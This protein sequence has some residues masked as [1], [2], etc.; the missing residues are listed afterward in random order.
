MPAQTRILEE[1]ARAGGWISFARY[2][3]LA[4]HEPGVGYYASGAQKF[5]RGGD[6]TTAPELGDLFGRTLARQLRGFDRVLEL[7]AGS[8][9]LAEVLVREL[10]CEY[11]I[12][13]TS[14]ELRARQRER[15]GDRVRHIDRLPER[16]RGAMLANEV[17][18]AMPVHLVHWT[19]GA[20]LER[21][22]AAPLAWADRPATGALLDAAKRIDVPMPYV[23]EVNLAARAWMR[24]L[25]EALDAGAIFIIDY[26]YPRHEYYHPQRDTGTLM[27]HYRHQAHADPFARPGEEDI[28]AHV[29]FTALA[30]AAHE[31][32][33]QVLGYTNQA[34]FLVNC[35]ITEVLEEANV[36]NALH[37]APIAAQAQKLLS[38]AEMGELFK[39]LAVGRGKA[40]PLAGFTRGE[41][42]HSL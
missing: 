16:F 15:L 2:M 36:E 21:G 9:A 3:Q 24:S 28:T 42:S 35:G 31:A 40:G 22:V 1:I 14:A 29:D 8:G 27:C 7:G 38:P 41:R 4:L 17:V 13:E 39:V 20:I 19:P 37:Y 33:A 10:D 23:S 5:G 25:V 30:E 26:G 12:L 6:F 18:D 11:L 34:Q 32:G